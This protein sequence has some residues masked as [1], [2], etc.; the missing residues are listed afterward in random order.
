MQNPISVNKSAIRCKTTSGIC[1]SCEIPDENHHCCD[2]KMSVT[3]EPNRVGCGSCEGCET[4]GYSRCMVPNN[5]FNFQSCVPYVEFY[6]VS[7]FEY[8]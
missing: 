6:K 3:M 4:D 5:I 8:K 7:Y 1:T 2:G